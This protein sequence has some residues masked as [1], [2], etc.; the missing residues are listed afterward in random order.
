MPRRTPGSREKATEWNEG[1]PQ[2]EIN[3]SGAFK[4]II[5]TKKVL[6][7]LKI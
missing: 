5:A 3:P 4:I 1:V 2:S 7:F 6:L